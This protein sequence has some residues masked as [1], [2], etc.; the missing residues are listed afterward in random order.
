V[1]LKVRFADFTT[2]TRSRTLP[3]AVDTAHDLYPAARSLLE[4]AAVGRRRVRLLG[5]GG[6]NLEDAA[7]PRQ[8]GLEREQWGP[9]EEAVGR[10]RERFGGAA[11]RR[12]RLAGPRGEAGDPMEE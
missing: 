7:A 12:A 11:V 10:V 1:S 3:G 6:E 4:R 5:L 8:L 9:V 2:I